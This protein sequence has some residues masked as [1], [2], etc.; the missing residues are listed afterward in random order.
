MPYKILLIDD[1]MTQLEMLRLQF[2]KAGFEIE[3]AK[4][5]GEAYKK[6]FET[7]PDLILSDIIM[8]NLNGYQLCRLL[9]NN[10]VTK[11][12]PVVLL[13]VLDKKID[14]FWGNKSGADKFISKTASFDDIRQKVIDIIEKKSHSFTIKISNFFKNVF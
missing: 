5:G 7:A 11:N 1:S 3:V 4:D 13:T 12:I 2:G 8:P 14:K 6:V 9:K 10:P